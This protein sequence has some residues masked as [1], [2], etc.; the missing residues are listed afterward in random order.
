MFAAFVLLPTRF[1]P[2]TDRELPFLAIALFFVLSPVKTRRNRSFAPSQHI[3]P[4]QEYQTISTMTTLITV[5]NWQLSEMGTA[6]H[7]SVVVSGNGDMRHGNAPAC[8]PVPFYMPCPLW[9][10]I[11]SCCLALGFS[12]FSAIITSIQTVSHTRGA[13]LQ[14]S[15]NHTRSRGRVVCYSSTSIPF[16]EKCYYYCILWLWNY[17]TEILPVH[18]NAVEVCTTSV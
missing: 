9:L 17:D 5:V 12:S 8:S 1:W 13:P 4:E 11:Y 6:R 18:R 7:M 2:R 16:P 10:T 14:I 15:L 3:T